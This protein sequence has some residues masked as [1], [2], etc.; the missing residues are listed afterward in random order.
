MMQSKIVV[1]F[2][3]SLRVFSLFLF[4][5]VT[6]HAND[7]VCAVV[8]IEIQQ[9]LTLER[10]AFEATLVIENALDDKIIENVAVDLLFTDANDEP[11][12]FTHNPNGE[13][14]FFVQVISQDNIDDV[15]GSGRLAGGETATIKW[16]II[17]VPGT[18]QGDPQGALY[19]IGANFHYQLDGNDETIPVTAD[20]IRVKPMPLLKID[21]FLPE[22]VNGDNP[23][24]PEIEAPEPFTFGVLVKNNG[25][26]DAREVSIKSGQPQIVENEQGL[27][28]DFRLLGSMVGDAPMTSSLN[29]HFPLIEPDRSSIGR[30]L[31][32][33]SLT[34]RFTA[35]EADYFHA[36]ELG[37]ELTS[38]ID[39]TIDTHRLVGDVVLESGKDT[40]NDFLI[41]NVGYFVFDS[42]DS[43]QYP[44]SSA[45]AIGF[46][47]LP[48]VNDYQLTFT[49]PAGLV[50]TQFTDPFA[51]TQS[52][53]SVVRSDGKVLPTQNAWLSKRQDRSTQQWLYF[54]NIFDENT[55]GSYHIRF[56]EADN[57]PQP[58]VIQPIAQ[59]ITYEGGQLNVMITTSD[60]NGDNVTLSATPLPP[61]ATLTSETSNTHRLTWSPQIGQAGFYTVRV[62]ASD[63]QLSSFK[64]MSIVVNPFDDTDG[65]GLNDDWERENFDDL[66]RD[67]SGDFDGDGLND[68]EEFEQGKNPTV[69]D[70]PEKPLVVSP[71]LNARVDTLTP[72]LRI[73]NSE[74][75]GPHTLT[76]VFE[77]FSDAG[78][79][80]LV[81]AYYSVI[82]TQDETQWTVTQPLLENGH[83][84]WRARSYNG[85]VYSL[86]ENGNFQ[87]NTV[88]EAPAMPE[89][90]SPSDNA[91]V[92]TATPDLTVM[93]TQDPDGDAVFYQF[94]VFNEQQDTL[95]T[96]SALLP[97][98]TSGSTTWK[99]S[100]SLATNRRYYWQV[101]AIDEY[102]LATPSALWQFYREASNAPPTAPDILTPDD[103]AT[104]STA[105]VTII[106]TAAS[107]PNQDPLVYDLQLDTSQQFNTENLITEEVLSAVDDKVTWITPTLQENTRYYFRIKARDPAGAESE[108]RMMTF[109]VNAQ[110]DPPST[111]SI[112]NPGNEAWV[113]TLTPELVTSTAVDPDSSLIQYHFEVATDASMQNI[114]FATTSDSSTVIT[115]PLQDNQWYFWRVRAMDDQQAYSEYTPISRFF[116]NENNYNDPPTFMWAQPFHIGILH[117]ERPYDLQW[118]D[119]DPDSDAK[120]QLGF[121]ALGDS[122]ITWFATDLSEDDDADKF[123]L[124]ASELDAG[125]YSFTA[126][127]QDENSTVTV[128]APRSIIITDS[129]IIQ[130][131]FLDFGFGIIREGESATLSVRLS[132]QPTQNVMVPIRIES[133]SSFI[134]EKQSLTFTPE[135][136]QD[137]QDITVQS[138]DDCIAT[139]R[140]AQHYLILGKGISEDPAYHDVE[141]SSRFSFTDN[142]SSTSDCA[143]DTE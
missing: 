73:K 69:P 22:D 52:I 127:I 25:S 142:D 32:E 77:I 119:Y 71:L 3:Y 124:P 43:M 129:P 107:D 118:V 65:D 45:T 103:N 47:P 61:G 53:D 1:N 59:Q 18:S 13:G 87:V 141:S 109:V 136:W 94:F 63:G 5:Q 105:V 104:A 102:G 140:S 9:E 114:I 131:I 44:V 117:R 92:N 72:S 85:F 60:P 12:S 93:N 11:V 100:P 130:G 99:V 83:Y 132:T 137:Y 40:L 46:T 125:I 82:E 51:G 135:N 28:I 126:I 75:T 74:Y 7:T 36:D 20:E 143:T 50:F 84:Y 55:T 134:L 62:T 68:R 111:P 112:I 56:R 54:I 90:S 30:W 81:D 120:I 76:Y 88:N 31:M 122:E 80:Q 101:K 6:L 89:L 70:G 138:I 15:T 42:F 4:T 39:G 115:D 27:L 2:F 116:A 78:L 38:L 35:F 14:D 21:Y 123:R 97:A 10:Q 41:E 16:L 26:G 139:D 48:T 64:D 79:T 17:P 37:G 98:N 91:P 24:T 95:I 23:F 86:W 133:P 110:N 33:T 67:G 34:G 49:A 19:Y 106:A 128:E 121:E 57:L 96:Q 8:K 66:S 108:W 29:L 58:P 113:A